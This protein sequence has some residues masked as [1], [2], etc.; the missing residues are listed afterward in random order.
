MYLILLHY[1]VDITCVPHHKAQC[2]EWLFDYCH[3][4]LNSKASLLMTLKY[5]WNQWFKLGQSWISSTFDH[6]LY[7]RAHTCTIDSLCDE[8]SYNPSWTMK[9]HSS[10]Y[11]TQCRRTFEFQN[12]WFHKRTW[13][14]L[15]GSYR[16]IRSMFSSIQCLFQIHRI[17]LSR[18]LVSSLERM[19]FQKLLLITPRFWS[20][21]SIK[22]IPWIS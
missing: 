10:M 22:I 16:H 6:Y 12:H 19:I 8:L 5:F 3:K 17:L 4:C 20:K 13:K 21:C 9:F 7:T 1:F 15:L 18:K 11:N 2:Q 14:I